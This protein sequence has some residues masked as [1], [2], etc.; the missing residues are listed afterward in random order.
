VSKSV[1]VEQEVPET[2]V[3]NSGQFA[4]T[5]H[6]PAETDDP[7]PACPERHRSEADYISVQSACYPTYSLCQN[8]ECFG[9]E[10][11]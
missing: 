4:D 5:L 2:V 11:Q 6:R 8:P 10:R 7:L 1:S 9:G 3:R